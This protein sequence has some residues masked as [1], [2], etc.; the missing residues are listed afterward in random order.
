MTDSQENVAPELRARRA[1]LKGALLSTGGVAA[2]AVGA[3][4][5]A[6]AAI[7]TEQV[8]PSRDAGY[9]ET[10]HVRAYYAAARF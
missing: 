6:S 1:F 7:Q 10:D 9:R 4:A 2:L 8:E 3:A 5:P